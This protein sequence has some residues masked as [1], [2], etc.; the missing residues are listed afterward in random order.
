MEDGTSRHTRPWSRLRINQLRLRNVFLRWNSCSFLCCFS[1]SVMSDSL[2][3]HGLQ[4]ARLPCPSLPPRV[5]LNSCPL[6]QWC[7]PTVSSCRS[8]LLLPSI[9]PSIRV[10]SSESALH[11]RWPKYWSLSLSISPSNECSGLISFR[12][13]WFDLAVLRT[14]KS[15]LQN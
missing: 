13:N 1:H 10:F 7:H 12:T 6:S 15:L 2:Q 9:V 8:L 11:I 4:H 5:C 3:P 14:L